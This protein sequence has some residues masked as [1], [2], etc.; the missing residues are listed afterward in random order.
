MFSNILQSVFTKGFVAIIN[1]LVF[2]ISA[3]YLGTSSRGEINILVLNIAIIQILNEVYTGYSLIYFIPKYNL[4]KIFITGILYTFIACSLGN[5]LFYF[6]GKQLPGYEWLSFIISMLVILNTFSCVLI[7]GKE[8]IGLYNFLCV[9]QPLILLGGLCYSILYLKIFTLEAYLFPM[10]ISFG[11]AF[12]I[13]FIGALKITK[14]D[15]VKKVFELK[16][17]ISYGLICQM[18]VLLYI[19]SNKYSYYLLENN[20]QVG[21]YG[22]A[23]SLIESILII[24][25]GISPVFLARVANSGNTLQNVRMTLTLSKLSCILSIASVFLILLIPN[26]IYVSV[27]G[28]G[29]VD[30]KSYM[31]LYSPGI[32]IMSFIS[33]INN[34]F[35]AIGKLKQVLICNALG[36]LA[37]LIAAHMLIPIYGITG[38]AIAANIAYAI[39]A[40]AITF[41]FLQSNNLTFLNLVRFKDDYVDFIELMKK[42]K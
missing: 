15:I 11:L 39:T 2:I 41:F 31:L 18:G 40:V 23:C 35:S 17:I 42:D 5:Y 25:N 4:K 8:K 28:E 38:A 16:P 20:S 6:I 27:L 37:S 14:E 13:S 3:K 30:V 1:F 34:Y 22:T 9:F 36:F 12:P 32:I 24:A 7:L 26:K 19:L 21:L 10:L 29:Y 33:I